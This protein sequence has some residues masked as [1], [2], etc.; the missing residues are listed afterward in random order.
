MFMMTAKVDKKRLCVFL[1]AVLAV[2]ALV[3]FFAR[4]E[5]TE[6]A[7]GTPVS[8]ES[9]E[10]RVEFLSAQ[11][12]EVASAPVQTQPVRIPEETNEVL[13]RYNTLQKTQGYD[14]SRYA[15]K[16]V[17]RYV[18]EVSN[19]PDAS[20]PVYATL[21]VYKD[22]VV[23]GDITETAANGSVHPLSGDIIS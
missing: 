9:N 18:Y 2:T 4:G 5:S 16:V 8:M 17:T 7:E 3:C 6:E 11:G 13:E 20:E 12:W 14:L 15:G 10:A 1:A 23:G 19:Y 22:R 21:L